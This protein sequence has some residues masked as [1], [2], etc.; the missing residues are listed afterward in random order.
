[1]NQHT[2]CIRFEFTPSGQIFFKI[3]YKKSFLLKIQINIIRESIN[4][5]HL[6]I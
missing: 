4:H 1:M 6:S 3:I 2:Y 5:N